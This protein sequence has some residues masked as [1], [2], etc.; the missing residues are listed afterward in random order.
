ML[1]GKVALVTGGSRGIGRSIALELVKAGAAVVI[2]YSKDETGANDTLRLIKEL[3][4]FGKSIL[5]DVSIYKDA[6][7]MIDYTVKSFGRIDILINNAGISHVGLF[8]DMKEQQWNNLLDVDLKGVIN[9][10]HYAL[11]YMA[12]QKKGNIINISSIWG[13]SGASCETI[14]SAAK[15]AVNSFTKALAKEMAPSNIRVNAIAPGVIN[16]EMNNWLSKEEK[17]ELIKEIPLE[18]FGNGEDIG[19]LA[20]FLASEASNYITGQIITVDGGLLWYYN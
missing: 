13:N 4:G 6:A 7:H 16:T 8:M 3:G 11:Q 17:D 1:N 2:S 9:C 19:K 14:Y 10:S 20:V 15:G 12:R 5:G 18:R